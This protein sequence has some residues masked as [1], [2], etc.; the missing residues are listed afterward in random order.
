M[1]HA[2]LLQDWLTVQGNLRTTIIPQQEA[3]YADLIDYKDVAIYVHAADFTNT[4]L[5][6]IQTSPTREEA[7]F[8]TIA[9]FSITTVGLQAIAVVRHATASIPLTRWVR[10]RLNGALDIYRLTF[11]IWLAGNPGHTGLPTDGLFPDSTSEQIP[12][13]VRAAL[14]MPLIL[15]SVAERPLESMSV[16]GDPPQPN[17][18]DR[19][20]RH[21]AADMLQ[22]RTRGQ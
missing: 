10:W 11:R 22:L 19:L 17:A 18:V 15:P 8:R 2:I 7:F 9:S 4:P 13:R 21:R 12:L 3:S 1:C 14:D 5:L 6:E 16:A 20:G